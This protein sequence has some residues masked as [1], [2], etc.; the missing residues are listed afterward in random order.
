MEEIGIGLLVWG[1]PSLVVLFGMWIVITMLY[2]QD[3]YATVRSLDKRGTGNP[4]D[5]LP[6]DGI[7]VLHSA[8]GTETVSGE[9]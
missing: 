6:R 2:G 4:E 8:T 1:A 7:S 9:E 5:V 3:E